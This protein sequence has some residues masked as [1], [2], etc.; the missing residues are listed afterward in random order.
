MR[1]RCIS[2]DGTWHSTH[3][4]ITAIPSPADPPFTAVSICLAL[5]RVFAAIEV[6]QANSTTIGVIAAQAPAF[7]A[8]RGVIDKLESLAGAWVFAAMRRKRGNCNRHFYC[9]YGRWSG[10]NGSGNAPARA[11]AGVKYTARAGGGVRGHGPWEERG[12]DVLCH[13]AVER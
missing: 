1:R 11:G 10:R 8:A 12:G 6:L 5:G 9:R 4:I 13:Y 2:A 3:I 7:G